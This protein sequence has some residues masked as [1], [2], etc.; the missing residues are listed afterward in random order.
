[1]F[2]IKTV[3]IDLGGGDRAEDDGFAKRRHHGAI[4]LARNA[5]GFELQRLAAEVDF[6]SL[7]IKHLNSFAHAAGCRLA[8]T[9]MNP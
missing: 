9:K 3:E 7:D 8:R 4:G 1:M 2:D 6:H 5:A